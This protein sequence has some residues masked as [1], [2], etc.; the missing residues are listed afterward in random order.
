V[1]DH[2]GGERQAGV[3]SPK[4]HCRASLTRGSDFPPT[5]RRKR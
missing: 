4:Q 1:A 5:G 2:Q 3:M